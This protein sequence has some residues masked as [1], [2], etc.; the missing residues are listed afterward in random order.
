[1]A[2]VLLVAVL[3]VVVLLVVVLLVVAA[4]VVLVAAAA[5]SWPS[6]A[7][8]ARAPVTARVAQTL[9]TAATI[10]ARAAG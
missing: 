8:N 4:A 10:R 1:M 5:V 3:L 9:A 7:V 2:A 6:S